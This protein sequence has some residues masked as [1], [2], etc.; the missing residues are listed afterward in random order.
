MRTKRAVSTAVT[1]SA[2]VIAVLVVAAAFYVVP[3]IHPAAT[4]TITSTVTSTS[5][6]S[7]TQ[8]G[9]YSIALVLGG[10]ETDVGFNYVAIQAANALQQLYGWNVS[11]SRDV[12][13]AN[14]QQVITSLAQSGKYTL[15]WVVGNQYIGMTEAIANA[16]YKAGLKTL[17]AQTPSYYQPLTP[18]IVVLDQSF[19]T[20]AWYE[21][22]AL[23][24][25]MTKT[26][27]IGFVIGQWFP[28]QSEEFYAFVAGKNATNPSAK[29]YATVAGTWSDPSLGAQ[30]TTTMIQTHQT[31]IIAEVADATG[32]GVYTAAQQYN[33]TVIGTVADQSVL[34]PYNT[35]TSTLAN[36]SAFIDPVAQHIMNG[37]W[38]QIGG[39]DLFMQIGSLAPYHEYAISGSGAMMYIPQSVQDYI[40]SVTAQ[41]N[42]GKIT[43]GNEIT[44]NPPTGPV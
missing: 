44:S 32:R 27:S 40:T 13:Y 41:V 2:V 42:S 19:Q 23:A 25:K 9:K 3:G 33:A 7:T 22:G 20:Q 31:D 18:N 12:P 6:G 16:S 15:I 10:D 21:A 38:S 14:T 30:I 39:K 8:S 36:F 17:F 35:M 4:T 34:A 43:V 24:A 29:V 5:S 11:I 1:I 28:S 37:T 26:N